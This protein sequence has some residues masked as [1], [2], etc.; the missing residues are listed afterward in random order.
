[1]TSDALNLEPP[2]PPHTR[3]HAN[4]SISSTWPSHFSRIQLATSMFVIVILER[5]CTSASSRAASGESRWVWLH[6]INSMYLLYDDVIVAA[7]VFVFS[8]AFVAIVVVLVFVFFFLSVYLSVFFCS[9]LV[10]SFRWAS[11]YTGSQP[12]SNL[13]LANKLRSF[14]RSFVRMRRELGKRWDT[15]TD[16]RTDGRTPDRY[17]MLFAR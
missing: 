10:A 7:I 4:A 6:F 17:I 12:M 9:F 1:M 2:S 15:H 13:L 11:A 16:R 8:L 5:K 3:A 14:I